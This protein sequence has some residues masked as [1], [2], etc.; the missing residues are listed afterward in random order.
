MPHDNTQHRLLR[1]KYLTVSGLV[2]TGAIAGCSG[3]ENGAEETDPT[4]D[5]DTGDPE[6]ADDGDGAEADEE[7]APEYT[8]SGEVPE[9]VEVGEDL[10]YS[11]T[12]TNSG[13]ATE[14]EF[15]LDISVVG[16]D[17]WEP[18]FSY[19]TELASGESESVES[20]PFAFGESGTIQWEFWV[21][22]VGQDDDVAAYET[23][24]TTPTRSWGEPYRTPTDLIVTVANPRLT[25][26]YEYE[27]FGG[28][29]E[30]HR[31]P[32]GEQ[33]AFVDLIVEND[34]G[35][36]REL[37]NR[38]SFELVG[39]SQQFES[40][41]RTEYERDDD[42]DGLRTVVDGVVGEGVLPFQIPDGVT[43]EEL[44]LFY[45][46]FDIDAEPSS[47]EVTWQ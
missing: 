40:M 8:I 33:F 11:S 19:E 24:V 16:E 41:R 2:A 18:V 25:N 5:D 46:D 9:E 27:G 13:T 36:S 7:Q 30:V 22:A 3:D 35:E 45:N 4:T 42:Y 38:L 6:E 28:D 17:R 43:G 32:D 29:E 12:V 31:A 10:T 15:G 1:R 34:A 14:A 44:Q 26:R 39:G 23:V 21:S 20:D 47:W 37:P